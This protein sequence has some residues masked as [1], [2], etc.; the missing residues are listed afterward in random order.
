VTG[1]LVLTTVIGLSRVYLRAHYLSDVIAGWALG[2]T[3]FAICG[4]VAMVVA[5]IRHNPRAA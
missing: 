2:L 3:L 5:Y 1:A 4:I